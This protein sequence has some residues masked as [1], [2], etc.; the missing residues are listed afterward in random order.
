MPRCLQ[1]GVS[2]RRSRLPRGLAAR[3][4][5][6]AAAHLAPVFAGGSWDCPHTLSE[7]NC[8]VRSPCPHTGSALFVAEN[9]AGSGPCRA[10]A[11]GPGVPRVL[12]DLWDRRQQPDRVSLCSVVTPLAPHAAERLS[13]TEMGRCCCLLIGVFLRASASGP[14]GVTGRGKR[15]KGAKRKAVCACGVPPCTADIRTLLAGAGSPCLKPDLQKS[16]L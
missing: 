2:G 11:G 8:R 1:A 12:P 15:P 13:V 4:S 10:G 14:A 9:K 16:P 7:A 3:L 6:G 5:R